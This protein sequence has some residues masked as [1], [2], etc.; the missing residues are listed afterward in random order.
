MNLKIQGGASLENQVLR[1]FLHGEMFPAD[2]PS[3]LAGRLLPGAEIPPRCGVRSVRAALL[4]AGTLHDAGLSAADPEGT[5]ILS[6][7]RSGSHPEN[8]RYWHD[9]LSAG[10][11]DGRGRF[12]V[13][14][15]AT[16]PV[17][18]AAI[19]CGI[20]GGILYLD[21]FGDRASARDEIEDL[22]DSGLQAVM[23]T[24]LDPPVMRAFLVVRG[25]AADEGSALPL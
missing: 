12:F 4:L 18:D 20:R 7:G 23:L 8:L 14:T 3:T 10:R 11:T 19:V 25:T 5:A 9:Y 1:T 2:D 17:C 15:L 24:L 16:T 22:L 13:G 6:W 21:T